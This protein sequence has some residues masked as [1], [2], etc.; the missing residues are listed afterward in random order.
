MST[1]TFNGQQQ[2]AASVADTLVTSLDNNLTAFGGVHTVTLEP[3]VQFDAVYGLLGTDHTTFTANG[4]SV[5]ASNGLFVCNTNTSAGGYAV[6]RSKR[7][8]RYRAGQGMRIEFTAAFTA[9]VADSLQLAGGFSATEGLLVGFQ[10]AEFGVMRRQAGAV[11]IH[12]LTLSA[13]SGGAETITVTLNGV[14]FPI[15]SGGAKTAAALAQHLASQTYTGWSASPPQAVGATVTWLQDVPAATAGAFTLASTGTAAGSFAT[16]QAGAPNVTTGTN[17]WI[18][19]SQWNVDK[20]DGAGPSGITLDPTKLNIYMVLLPFLGAG[21]ITY[22]IMSPF[23]GKF[24]VMHRLPYPNSATGPNLRNPT[25]HV[26]LISASLGSTSA[27]AVSGASGAALREGPSQLSIRGPR[28]VPATNITATTTE[29]TVL[30][31]RGRSELGG[32]VNLR[33]IWPIT[34]RAANES[35]T[36]TVLLRCY[37]DPVLAGT[38]TWTRVSSESSVDYT[39][40][41]L[42]ISSGAPFDVATLN[43]LGVIDVELHE[44]DIRIGPGGLIAVTVQTNTSTAP[45]DCTVSWLEI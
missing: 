22:A 8:A 21:P 1:A 14:A 18:P 34:L 40:D 15:A 43:P 13:G 12:R 10:G 45:V 23:D 32:T 25:L 17:V 33:E 36:R 7:V 35:S 39:L 4:G 44:S 29:T 2:V 24:Y 26:G 38:P 19:Q 20:L 27:L 28:A 41:P 31:L 42:T 37:A 3:R 11:A 16:V 30:V 6:L 5:T 9:G